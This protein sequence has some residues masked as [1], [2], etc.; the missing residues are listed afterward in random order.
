MK[1][2]YLLKS[3]PKNRY[4]VGMIL[5]VVLFVFLS[6]L[7]YMFP[8]FV[9]STSYTIGRPVWLIR[10]GVMQKF[11]ELKGYF[12]S[13]NSLVSENQI[14]KDELSKL[15]LKEIDYG[16]LSGEFTDMKNQMGRKENTARIVSRVLSKPPYSPYDTLIIDVGS[17]DGVFL[18]NRVYMSDNI[19]VG[20]VKNVTQ[21]TS[22]VELFSSGGVEQEATV[23]RTGATFTL[24]GLGGANIE[25]EVPKDTDIIWGDV[26]LYPKFTPS[27][28]GSIYFIDS[29]SQN[30]FK[31]VYVR[32]PGNVFSAKY[33]FVSN[34]K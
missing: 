32:L 27:M 31:K 7:I 14:L 25:L 18:G 29:N 26:F 30:S 21:H 19:I 24:K 20:I 15:R 5:V 2:N 3:K 28:I 23:A 4:P 13:K 12:V 6:L 17:S 10:D 22:L 34:D 11:S 1:M 16:V 33:V 9:R 8:D